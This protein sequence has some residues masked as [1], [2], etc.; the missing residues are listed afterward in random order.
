MAEKV[1]IA[2]KRHRT[3]IRFISECLKEWGFKVSRVKISGKRL[4]QAEGNGVT[5]LIEHQSK[6]EFWYYK[7]KDDELYWRLNHEFSLKKDD[8]NN[9]MDIMKTEKKVVIY[10]RRYYEYNEERTAKPSP[11]NSRIWFSSPMHHFDFQDFIRDIIY[12][13][14]LQDFIEGKRYLTRRFMPAFGRSS[15]KRM[16]VVDENPEFYVIPIYN[17]IY[18]ETYWFEFNKVSLLDKTDA[19]D[20]IMRKIFIKAKDLF[21]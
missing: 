2:I 6:D 7:G 1:D 13:A 15:K 17:D 10:T 5:F 16:L 21:K 19:W 11:I 9:L 12:G 3:D 20:T 14:K 8:V 18:N 4:L